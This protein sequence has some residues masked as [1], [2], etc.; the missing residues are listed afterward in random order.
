[1]TALTDIEGIGKA[2]A[3]KLEAAGVRSVESLLEMGGTPAGRKSIAEK[4]GIAETHILEWVN[5]ADLYRI[6]GVGSE[7]SDLL[8]EAGVDTVVELA[9]R[10]AAN[11]RAALETANEK[12]KLVRRLPTEEMLSGWI[13]QAKAL[14]RAVHH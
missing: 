14:P 5:H 12:K 10:N 8:E 9:R 6:K 13:E 7:F 2:Q 1:M 11:L 3:D 4:S